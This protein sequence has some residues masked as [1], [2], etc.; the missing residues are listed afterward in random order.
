M[1]KVLSV[2]LSMVMLFTLSVG[3]SITA[4]AA[5]PDEIVAFAKQQLGKPYVLNTHGPNT[6]DCYGLVYYVYTQKGIKGMSTAS[7]E[8]WSNPGKFGTKITGDANAKKGYICVW[9]GHV[10]ICIGDGKVVNALNASRGVCTIKITDY[11]NSKGTLNPSHFYIDVNGVT[12]TT[13]YTVT[14]DKNGG[15][16]VSKSSMTVNANSAMNADIPSA[17]KSGYVFDGWYTS[18][19]GGSRFLSSDKVTKN[20][21]LYAQWVKSDPNVLKVGDIVRIYSQKSLSTGSYRY[22]TASSGEIRSVI[23][24]QDAQSAAK[25]FF[26]VT[27]ID[28][29][30]FYSF[31]C[32][33]G[34]N[35]LDVDT[36]NGRYQNK[37]K[38]QVYTPKDHQAQKFGIVQRSGNIYSIH[39]VYS[40][41]ALD[42][43][44]NTVDAGTVIQQ[45][46][47]N[48]A[49]NQNFLFMDCNTQYQAICSH[50]YQ[51][52]S[53]IPS[54][55][56][57]FGSKKSVCSICGKEKIEYLPL[58]SHNYQTVVTK[59]T[60]TADG[61]IVEKCSVCGDI[62]SSKSISR[63]ASIKM[64]HIDYS[65]RAKEI[66]P[67]VTVRDSNG[68]IINSS[69]YTL[70][71]ANNTQVGKGT[72]TITFK[73]NY[74]GSKVRRFNILPKRITVSSVSAGKNSITWKWNK[75]DNVTGY[76][77]RYW[78]KGDF[79]HAKIT[80]IKNPNQLS[81]T[82]KKLSRDTDYYY[83]IRTYKTI[84][85]NGEKKAFVGFW[86]HTEHIKTK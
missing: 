60:M 31:E 58:A 35:A 24:L 53:T 11:V 71:Y 14:F 68:N 9:S 50:N 67:T 25:Q 49:T 40:G 56:K 47:Y 16:A 2:L 22:F 51:V 6:F 83:N 4:E 79:A 66:K 41:I 65:Y 52:M 29:N 46:Y 28:E 20:M 3:L 26:R 13:N 8:Y 45:Y 10:G 78:K 17:V 27:G 23:S 80:K 77:I 59:A 32:M 15:D 37:N 85:Y 38:L 30:G 5:T 61:S 82:I 64:S 55:C 42:C 18:A 69:N 73:G 81:R 39:N 86:S 7:S 34:Y 44:G 84:T 70:S 54:T 63:I 48:G 43:T 1:K 75:V 72:V 21:T 74:S 19:S 33:D 36:T 57:V 76:Q 62:R 12:D